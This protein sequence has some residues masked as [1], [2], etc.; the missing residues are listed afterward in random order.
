MFGIFFTILVLIRGSD[1]VRY[2]FNQNFGEVFYDYSGNY[3]FSVNGKNSVDSLRNTIGTDRGAYFS[4]GNSIITMPP[5]DVSASFEYPAV[6]SVVFWVLVEDFTFYCFYCK[7]KTGLLYL[8]RYSIGSKLGVYVSTNSFVVNEQ[9]SST[10]SF[11]HRI[12]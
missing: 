10:D 12:Y 5:N 2:K 1:L 7:S 9:F 3:L 11:S 8:R 4:V 6:F